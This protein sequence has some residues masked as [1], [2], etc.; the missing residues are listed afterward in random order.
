MNRV[1]THKAICH[2]FLFGILCLPQAASFQLQ[3][4]NR[5]NFPKKCNHGR[6]TKES[7]CSRV[8]LFSGNDNNDA[9]MQ[10]SSSKREQQ[11]F[12]PMMPMILMSAT[13]GLSLFTPMASAA[14]ADPR[15]E[16]HLLII[17]EETTTSTSSTP[18]SVS[19]YFSQ[20]FQS[21]Y[22]TPGAT[23]LP[24]DSRFDNAEARNRA[25]DQ[26]FEQDARD[27]DAYYG[28]MA[29]LKR[30]K[31]LQTVRGNRQALGLDGDGDV[32]L[33]VGEERVAG[34]SSLKDILLQRDPSTLTPAELKVY[35]QMQERQ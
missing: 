30:E 2:L 29:A 21:P 14:E 5:P 16:S 32:R 4:H 28:K 26:A 3:Q 23:P 18:T 27:R 24:T 13:F 15:T 31:A 25:Y 11:N 10:S 20:V 19:N 22:K 1:A 33:R 7:T 35:Q 6:I 9:S 17:N 34:M 8:A 12:L